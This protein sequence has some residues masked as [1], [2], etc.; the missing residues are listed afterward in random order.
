MIRL[1][2]ITK[3]FYDGVES[4]N[5]LKST[6]LE[7]HSNEFV[8]IVG[9]SGSGKSTLLTIIGALQTPSY[10][11]VFINEKDITKLNKKDAADLRFK[12]IGFILQ[13]SNLVPFLN[14]YDQFQMKLQQAKVKDVEKKINEMLESLSILNLKK[15]YPD[16]LSGGERQ[17]VAIGLALILKPQIILADEP[18]ASLDTQKA[19]QVVEL[20]S[21]ISKKQG[22]TVIMVT[23]DERML[24]HCDRVFHMDDGV[25]KGISGSTTPTV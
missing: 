1:S 5:V 3:D 12:A 20:L 21:E 23:H 15:K 25:L 24:S 8:A 9:P 19:F 10:G 7:I 16:E 13:G 2:N 6:D 14:V 17:R 11:S 22:T 18:T 4:I